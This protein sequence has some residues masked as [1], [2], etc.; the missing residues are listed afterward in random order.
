MVLEEAGMEFKPDWDSAKRR[1]AAWWHGEVVDR[2]VLQVAAPRAERI[3]PDPPPLEKPAEVTERW[4]DPAYRVGNAERHFASTWFGGEAFPY[5]D[6]HLGPGSLALYVGSEPVFA[7]DT[8]WYQPCLP[9]LDDRPALRVNP[10]NRWWQ[11]TKALVSE[12]VRRGQ[13]RYLTAIPDLIE[14]LDTVASLRGTAQLLWDLVD[15]PR[16]IHALQREVLEAYFECY[17]ELYAM[18]S[19]V[20]E[21]CCFSAFQVWA[22]GRMA[23]LQ[24]DFSAMISPAMFEEFVL[25]YLSQQCE[26]LDYSVYHLDGPDAVKHL[27]LLLSIPRLNVL[28]WTPGANQPGVGAEQW[29]DIYRRARQA[30]KSLL[31]A[32]VHPNEMQRLVETFGPEGLLVS[33]WVSSQAEG[34]ELLKAA[35][36]WIA[37]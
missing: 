23:K 20:G 26:R 5:F 31:L 21:G 18:V 13:G 7:D 37:R 15:H 3:G 17:D 24:C 6:P 1:L 27:D 32:G 9:D 36:T 4:L 11:A 33:T 34:E 29:F 10:A 2:F 22:P 30:E 16:P 25:P 28:Q 35:Q 8:V 12:G 14:N 19:S